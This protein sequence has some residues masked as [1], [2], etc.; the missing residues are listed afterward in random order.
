MVNHPRQL[1]NVCL[2]RICS[3]YVGLL[4]KIQK[5]LIIKIYSRFS[6]FS[7]TEFHSFCVIYNATSSQD[8]VD[9][10]QP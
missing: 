9:S 1:A 3:F 10:L 8:L 7:C 4:P 2:D 5:K 6:P